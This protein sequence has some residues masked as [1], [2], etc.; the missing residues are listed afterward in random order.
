MNINSEHLSPFGLLVRSELTDLF[1]LPTQ[2]LKDWIAKHRF[3]V[4]RGF[5]PL[6]GAQLPEFGRRFGELLEWDFGT[7][8][9][10]TVKA[11]TRNYLYSNHEVPFHWDGAFVDRAPH[12]ILFHCDD[13]PASG[14]GGETL[15]CDALRLL[16]Y[17]NDDVQKLWER[18]EI[19]YTTARIV[20]YGGTFTSPLI[21]RH[22]VSGQ[23]VLRYAEPVVDLN[24]VELAISGIPESEHDEFIRDMNHRL[25]DERC[26]YSHEWIRGDVVIADNLAL[27]HGRRAFNSDA[28]RRIRRVNIL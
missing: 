19:T 6:L 14:T 1:D 5:A 26:C 16:E 24:P 3:V 25:N 23:R 21:S 12:Y 28:P 8:N 2:Q 27:L 4:L 7:V 17:A 18:V 22:P 11:D 9:E 15:F 10:L 13:A 20:H